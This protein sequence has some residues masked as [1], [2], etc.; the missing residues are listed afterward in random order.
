MADV[1]QFPGAVRFQHEKMTWD[2]ITTLK[3]QVADQIGGMVPVSAAAVHLVLIY[4][5]HL[6][7]RLDIIPPPS[8]PEAA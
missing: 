4:V 3:A 2:A 7:G 1:I 5:E 8:D 6:A